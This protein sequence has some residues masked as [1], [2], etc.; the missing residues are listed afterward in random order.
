MTNFCH[1]ILKK[2]DLDVFTENMLISEMVS[3]VDKI[4]GSQKEK[5]VFDDF[6]F[7]FWSCDLEKVLFLLENTLIF[8]MVHAKAKRYMYGGL[9]LV[10]VDNFFELL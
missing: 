7:H 6:F 9:S 1:V 4:L 5:N 8:E 2:G 10:S 3:E